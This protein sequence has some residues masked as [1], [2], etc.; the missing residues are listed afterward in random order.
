MNEFILFVIY[1]ALSLDGSQGGP[2][3]SKKVEEMNEGVYESFGVARI[4]REV[5]CGMVKWV[6]HFT[7]VLWTH[8]E[9]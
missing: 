5:H 8:E 7:E 2:N 6:K 3:V 4:A 1:V 9:N